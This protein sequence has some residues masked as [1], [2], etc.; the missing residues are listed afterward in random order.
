M[1]I[2]LKYINIYI[3][4]EYFHQLEK[5][6]NTL[7]SSITKSIQNNLRSPKVL[8]VTR[9][10]QLPNGSQLPSLTLCKMFCA[11]SH[12]VSIGRHVPRDRQVP[13]GCQ[14]P[15]LTLHD[16]FHP[17]GRHVPRGC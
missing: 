10:R 17:N 16:T 14:T 2:T 4:K 1:S 3:D 15:S 8:S 13:S 12:H 11:D 7:E 6:S 5:F 9:G